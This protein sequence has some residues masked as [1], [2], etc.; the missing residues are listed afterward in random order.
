MVWL[1]IKAMFKDHDTLLDI[2]NNLFWRCPSVSCSKRKKTEK[3]TNI[4]S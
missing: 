2:H 3:Y 4:F 1:I